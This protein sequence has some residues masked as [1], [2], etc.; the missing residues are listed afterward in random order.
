[1]EQKTRNVVKPLGQSAV[2][3]E[4]YRGSPLA[5]SWDEMDWSISALIDFSDLEVVKC[6]WCLLPDS[7]KR[8]MMTITTAKC[9]CIV[10]NTNMRFSS[11][12]MTFTI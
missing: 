1:M 8:L 6:L 9:G 12:A 11:T 4:M 5:Y 7:D 3:V 10:H 2:W